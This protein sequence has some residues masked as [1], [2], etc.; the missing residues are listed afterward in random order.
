MGEIN[1]APDAPAHAPV[2]AIRDSLE[3]VN[4][5]IVTLHTFLGLLSRDPPDAQLSQDLRAEM[6]RELSSMCVTLEHLAR[7]LDPV[8]QQPAPA[9]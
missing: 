7:D 3:E 1:P 8:H 5:K 4:M 2:Q 9:P 6:S